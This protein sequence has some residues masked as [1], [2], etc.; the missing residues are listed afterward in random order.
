MEAPHR[1]NGADFNADQPYRMYH[2]NKIPGFPSHPH[3]GQETITATLEGLI[4][5]ADS[6]GNGGRY[7]Q[8]DLQWMTAGRGIVHSEMLPLIK[9]D[10]P[11]PVRFF[12]I[13]LNLPP[14]SKMANPSFAMF[15]EPTIPR[16]S[17]EDGLSKAIV[18][19]GEYLGVEKNNTPPPDSWASDKSNDVALVHIKIQPGGKFVLPKAHES[20]V[21]RSLFYIEGEDGLIVDGQVVSSRQSLLIDPTKEVVLEVPSTATTIS[22]LLWMQGKPIEEPVVQMGPFA[23]NTRQEISQAYADYEETQF[24]GWPWPRDDMVFPADKGRFALSNGVETRPSYDDNATAD[25]EANQ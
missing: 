17:S 21:N 13:W 24:G 4:D 5:H 2:G 16:W 10:E 14:R 11:N 7:G 1:G 22:E 25:K 18:W 19:I 8:G 9:T 12:Q 23:M 3:R 6:L 15:W 20:T